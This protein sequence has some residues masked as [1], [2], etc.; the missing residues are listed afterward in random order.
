MKRKKI[1]L[2]LLDILGVLVIIS[3]MAF[4]LTLVD[5]SQE[6][7]IGF[8]FFFGLIIGVPAGLILTLIWS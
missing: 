2:T 6:F 1:L 8:M 7:R 3:G 4:L 5:L